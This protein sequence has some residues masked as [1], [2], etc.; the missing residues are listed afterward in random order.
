[1]DVTGPFRFYKTTC[2]G[3]G[4][5]SS[6]HPSR[7]AG[8]FVWSFYQ[9]PDAGHFLQELYRYF[10]GPEASLTPAKGA[11]VL[12][13]LAGALTAGGPHLLV[14]DGLE[15]VQRQ[16]SHATGQFGQVEDPLLKGLITRL[17]EGVGQTLALV[18]SRFALTDLR[19]A[20]GHGY[21][22]I[23]VEGLSLSASLAL[24]RHHGVQGDDAALANLVDAYGAHALTLDHLGGLIGQFLG[25]DP[26]RAPEAPKLVSPEQDRQA[27]RLAR[28]LNAYAEHL[29]PAELALLCRLCL[30]QRS[31]RVEQILPLF[32][33]SPAVHVRSAREV[34]GL[35]QRIPIPDGLP[36]GIGAELA[37][38]VREAITEVLQHA[39]IAGPDQVFQ[40]SVRL[41]VES[42]LN[43]HEKNVET[44][45]E[46]L[47]RL[48]R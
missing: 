7:P 33:C 45:I 4:F 1:M 23:D 38:S 35:I 6:V 9:K 10:G 41:A 28:L 32:L 2:L 15:R 20:F 14:L 13:L 12:H 26:G 22:H 19:S 5:T 34:E 47:I 16:E 42:V 48:Y 29:P 40:E 39:P 30:L 11:A 36:E 31:A 18:T 25:G 37:A 46:E 44:D 27:L 43:E 17:A 3:H 24:L 8:L 21:H